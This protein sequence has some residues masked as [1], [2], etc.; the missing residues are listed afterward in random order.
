MNPTD[1]GD[2]PFDWIA[3]K[4]GT[5]VH[6]SLR[7]NCNNFGDPLT[8]NLAPSS[9]QNFNLCNTLVY[10]ELLVFASALVVLLSAT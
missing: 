9:G 5:H 8:F 6:A 7:I 2:P 1:F 10:D 4:F 3:V